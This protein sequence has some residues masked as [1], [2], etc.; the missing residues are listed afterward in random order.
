ME[1][2]TATGSGGLGVP[3]LV[4]PDGSTEV[5]AP[6]PRP[7]RGTDGMPVGALDRLLSTYRAIQASQSDV[8]EVM[9]LTVRNARSLLDADFCCI[10]RSAAPRGRVAAAEGH[11]VET[12]AAEVAPE[13]TGVGLCSVDLGSPVLVTDY[14]A[15]V[16]RSAHPV[17]RY[18]S[19]SE[20]VRTVL[21]LPLR[22]GAGGVGVLY[23]GHRRPRSFGATDVALA[24]ALAGQAALALQN[25]RLRR[26]LDDQHALLAHSVRIAERL[27]RAADS[28]G[29]DGVCRTLARE[30]GRRVEFVAEPDEEAVAGARTFAVVAGRAQHGALCVYGRPLSAADAVSVDQAT[31][32]IAREIVRRQTARQ[33]RVRSGTQLLRSLLDGVGRDRPHIAERARHIGFDLRRPVTV[34]AVAHRGGELAEL[35]LLAAGSSG[36]SGADVLGAEAA[37]HSVLAVATPDGWTPD[38]LTGDLL[39]HPDVG[40]L[41]VS[42][43]RGDLLA[44]GDEAVACLD[45]ARQVRGPRVVDAAGFG[46]LWFLI[47]AVDAVATMQD[48]LARSLGPVIAA[49]S[50]SGSPLLESLDA[51]LACGRRLAVAAGR[52]GVHPSTMKYRLAR[53]RTL[54]G[55]PLDGYHAFDL[56][57]AL[58][59][60]EVL[61]SLGQPGPGG[62]SPDG[63]P[64][65][66]S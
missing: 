57:L 28:S 22:D 41:G 18:L 35:Q 45:L 40:Y 12:W 46:P 24:S 15:Y 56:W 30:I 55:R 25:G 49:Q 61:V 62:G 29:V 53:I 1:S 4:H 31:G 39:A 20:G 52:I 13:E 6:G 26:E 32:L 9:R 5:W 10:W 19:G 27:S 60:R 58:R 16:D 36:L 47:G 66:G 48:H 33:A 8:D 14:R 43:A 11:L 7:Q 37:D 42:V 63:R 44:A 50:R 54:L 59:A 64:A 23:V 3:V 17:T 51:Y 65:K 38:G 2:R 21:C 34:V